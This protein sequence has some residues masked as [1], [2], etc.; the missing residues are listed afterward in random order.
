[1]HAQ[2]RIE[3]TLFGYRYGISGG[4]GLSAISVNDVVTFLNFLYGPQLDHRISEFNSSVEFY[5]VIDVFIKGNMSTG[6]EYSYLFGSHNFPTGFGSDDYSFSYHM[7]L[8]LGHYV[9]AGSGYFFKFGGGLGYL[10]A[11]FKEDLTLEPEPIVY[12]GG[13]IG[14]KLQAIGHTPFGDNLYAYIGVDFRFGFPGTVTDNDGTVLTDGRS[15]ISMNF[16]SF[17]L[18]FGLSYFF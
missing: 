11:R 9:I 6:I 7:P 13:G 15:D 10:F 17:G 4:M 14:G 1:M 3:S 12:S 16:F 5:G 18:K 2:E 8:L